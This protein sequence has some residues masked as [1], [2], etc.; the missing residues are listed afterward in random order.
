MSKTVPVREVCTCGLDVREEIWIC[1]HHIYR[2]GKREYESVTRVIKAL[3]P[4]DYADVEP[5]VLENARLKGVF[6]DSYF[7]EWLKTP[8]AM[9]S[10][11]DFKEMVEP[12]FSSDRYRAPQGHAE[13]A[14]GYA[15]GMVGQ[16]WNEGD[17]HPV[18]C[19]QRC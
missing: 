11:A 17:A 2:K 19:L 13:D 18:R 16:V 8:D 10:L 4:P 12:Y 3:M 5:P 14:L 7:C 6:I 15:L 9:L 1:P